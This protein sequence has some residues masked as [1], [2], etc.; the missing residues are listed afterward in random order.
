MTA[1]VD[2][3]K[4]RAAIQGILALAGRKTGR[5]EL[6]KLIYLA[7]NSFYESTGRTITG[8][9]YMWDHYGPNAVSQAIASEADNLAS[10]GKVRMAASP[11]IYGGRAFYYWVDDSDGTWGTIEYSLDTGECQ[12]L[13]DVAKRFGK[14]SLGALVRR[15]KET[16]PFSNARQYDLL[17]LEQ[18]DGAKEMRQRLASSGDFLEEVEL[19]FRD[20]D[21]GNWVEDDE[22]DS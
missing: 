11:S 16:R 13:I 22:L 7:D 18:D 1:G 12:I 2:I 20:A 14:L 3:P 9:A 5:T 21:E 15:S 10:F 8:N 19:G 4:T 17:T 6:V